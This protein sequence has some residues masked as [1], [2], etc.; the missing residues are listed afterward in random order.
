MALSK[1]TLKNRIKSEIQAVALAIGLPVLDSNQLELYS[2]AM[3]NAIIDE[4]LANAE[5]VVSGGSSSG[6]WPII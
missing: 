2:Q 3:A 6:N 5:V 4:F 1:V